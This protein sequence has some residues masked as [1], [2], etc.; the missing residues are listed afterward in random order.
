VG[1]VVAFRL[2]EVAPAVATSGL[3]LVGDD[4]ALSIVAAI[5]AAVAYDIP[6]GGG[7]AAEVPD[8]ASAVSTAAVV[9]AP[10]A[11]VG[12]GADSAPRD[13][14]LPSSLSSCRATSAGDARRPGS[15]GLG[16]RPVGR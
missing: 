3:D 15:P 12:H 6:G 4:R 13:E 11:A 9:A 2:Q 16:R 8:G 7:G 5:V 1:V 10:A 14:A